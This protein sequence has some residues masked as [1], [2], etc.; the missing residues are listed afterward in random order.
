MNMETKLEIGDQL[1][2][3]RSIPTT[4]IKLNVCSVVRVTERQALT[5]DGHKL[6]RFSQ[7]D[8]FLKTDNSEDIFFKLK[9]V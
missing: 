8:K 1:I 7:N 2:E 4:N 5:N 3:F 6:R 9:T